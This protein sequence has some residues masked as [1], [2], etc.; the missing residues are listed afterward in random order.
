MCIRDRAVAAR[1]GAVV[2]LDPRALEVPRRLRAERERIK[3]QLSVAREA[4]MR[5][6]PA[7]PP[8]LPGFQLAASCRPAKEVGGDLYDFIPFDGE[9]QGQWGIA[10]GDVSGKGM[11]ASLYMTLTKG[12][13][14]AAAERTDD[15]CAMLADVNRGLY[16]ESDRNI[17]VTLWYGILDPATRRL[18]HVRAGHNPALWR[19]AERGETVALKPPGFAL[20]GTSSKLFNRL[21]KEEEITLEEGDGL[22]IYSDGLTE[23]MNAEFEEYGD[24]RLA[25]AIARTDGLS[26][27]R[28]QNA[29]LA[30]VHAFIGDAQQHDDMTMVVLRVA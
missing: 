22:F 20:G 5:M 9:H 16:Q 19:R 8:K 30:D 3:A 7:A 24:E 1:R 13:L 21:L 2:S 29:I 26:A 15:P 11:V 6:L 12:L 14:L 25:Q 10:L 23:A 4:Q 28:A 27:E 18:R 17:F